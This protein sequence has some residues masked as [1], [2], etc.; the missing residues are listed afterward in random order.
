[1]RHALYIK[2]VGG[3]ENRL[4]RLRYVTEQPQ[5]HDKPQN[6]SPNT[7]GAQPPLRMPLRRAVQEQRQQDQYPDKKWRDLHPDNFGHVF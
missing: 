7:N 5:K 2:M 3:T 6:D 4:P 1:M